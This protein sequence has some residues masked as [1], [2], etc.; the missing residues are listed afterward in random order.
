[1]TAEQRVT[2]E[3]NRFIGDIDQL[4]HSARQLSGDSAA[5][6]RQRLEDKVAQARVRLEATRGMAA[7]FEPTGANVRPWWRNRSV[8]LAGLGVLAG[9]AVT[10]ALLARR[11]RK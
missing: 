10:S 9:A 5:L 3:F 2:Q 4:L 11:T 7:S 8:Q 6:V 1:M